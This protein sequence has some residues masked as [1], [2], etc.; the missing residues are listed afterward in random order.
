MGIKKL[1]CLLLACLFGILYSQAQDKLEVDLTQLSLEELMSLEVTTALKKPQK[2][3][4]VSA[5]V[6]VLS[7][8]EINR[9]GS[10]MIADV[11]RFIPG[12]EV[13]AIDANK[14]AISAR[15][16]GDRFA[17]KL[18]VSIDGRSV[19]NS[20]FSG[21]Y[22]DVQ[23]FILED[24][25]RIEIIRG[26][27]ASL[28]GANAVNGV[29]NVLSK[30][31]SETLGGIISA[32]IGNMDREIYGR[33]GFACGSDWFGRSY[34]KHHSHENRYK[35]DGEKGGDAWHT[36]QWG[37]RVDGRPG[38]QDQLT[39]QSDIYHGSRG[40]SINFI[41]LTT[42]EVYPKN[43]KGNV[44]GGNMLMRW[45]RTYS[46]QSELILHGFVDYS[47]REAEELNQ[48]FIIGDIDVQ[49]RIVAGDNH[50]L[51]YGGE[52]RFTSDRLKG[53]AFTQMS[54]ETKQ[55]HLISGFFQ[56]EMHLFDQRFLLTAG[57][58]IEY[59][60]LTGLEIQPTVRG[61]WRRNNKHRLWAAVSRA[62]RT[63]SRAERN[64]N[65]LAAYSPPGDLPLQGDMP[66]LARITGQS[67]FDSETVMAHEM[68]YRFQP[69]SNF[70]LDLSFFYNQYDHLRIAGLGERLL[71]GT[72]EDPYIEQI[73][74]MENGMTC[75]SAGFETILEW[76]IQSLLKLRLNYSYLNMQFSYDEKYIINGQV[77][78]D[79]T[80]EKSPDHQVILWSSWDPAST[81]QLD[82]L[83]HYQTENPN[84]ID[85]LNMH[86]N[87]R[88]AWQCTSMIT[89]A[90]TGQ[91]LW[92]SGKTESVTTFPGIL[93]H[94]ALSTKTPQS[95]FLQ[96]RIQW[97]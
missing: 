36:Y 60:C 97:H 74:M 50:E 43:L 75:K 87:A 5:S 46:H 93:I 57:S 28:W 12:M 15:G 42:F 8:D 69:Q 73:L 17:N 4:D 89:I 44:F 64:A 38:N 9:S 76:D 78:A 62:V 29:I 26:P 48:K 79:Y 68:G 66:L 41:N 81:V 67:G 40:R 84:I 86:V 39:V 58:K 80:D 92:E 24:I 83:G 33:Y 63:P 23:D 32:G 10:R 13:N 72:W 2:V 7:G 31:A 21:V 65:I 47:D 53:T 1:A 6:I 52:Y 85:P 55:L 61:L 90:L 91:N 88:L 30:P 14:W 27:G 71:M 25:Q 18:L 96:I 77:L 56:D 94:N 51:I 3:T 82:I 37:M 70:Y 95:F 34:V 19:Y 11:L 22:W 54:P 35:T 45:K 49:H 20:T 16:F 59:N